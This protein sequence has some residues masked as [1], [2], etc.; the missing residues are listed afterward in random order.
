MC[1][2]TGESQMEGH[3]AM[4]KILR[5]NR[6]RTIV[7]RGASSDQRRKI[8]EAYIWILQN[9]MPE[10]GEI[11]NGGNRSNRLQTEVIPS[12]AGKILASYFS[13]CP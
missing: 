12:E 11:E 2:R 1:T 7:I 5:T 8:A 9:F 10:F 6:G 13:C 3:T 4:R